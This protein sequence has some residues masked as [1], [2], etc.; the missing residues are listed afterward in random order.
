MALVGG[1]L[2]ILLG[3]TSYALLT[4]AISRPLGVDVAAYWNAAERLRDGQPLY[5]AGAP[6]A[7]DLYRYA[8]W[9]AV[10]WIP[11]TYLPHDAVVVAWVSLMIAAAVVSTVP[12]LWRGPTG[13]AAFAVFMPIQLQGA[14][15]GNV[16]PLL[17]LMLMWAVERRSGPLWI[18][19]GASL[20]ATPLALALVYAG[21]GEWRK[22]GWAALFTAVLVAP[23]LLFDLSAYPTGPGPNQISLAGVSM[24]LFVPLAL[25]SLV[26]AYTMARTRYGWL[27]GA[28]AVVATTPRLLTYQAGYILVGLPF[29]LLAMPRSVR[30]AP[31]RQAAGPPR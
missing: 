29:E 3:L 14:V 27:A 5:L 18:A 21:R 12:L 17:V 24:F 6:N 10:A 11:L 26:A 4:Y 2:A 13:W 22:A 28:V 8:P 31:S 23:M 16:Q 25:G 20:K 7:S 19:V 1:G 30:G 15:F 9:F